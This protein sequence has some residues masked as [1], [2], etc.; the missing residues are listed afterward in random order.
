[1]DLRFGRWPSD[2]AVTTAE[3]HFILKIFMVLN[4]FGSVLLFLFKSKPIVF[5]C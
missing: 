4:N 1:M 3:E 5:C 2:C